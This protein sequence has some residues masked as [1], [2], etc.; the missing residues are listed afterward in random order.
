MKESGVIAGLS[1]AGGEMA[2]QEGHLAQK[3]TQ[4]LADNP[5]KSSVLFKEVTESASC[6]NMLI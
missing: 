4:Q 2:S 3:P 6:K 1:S 5:Q